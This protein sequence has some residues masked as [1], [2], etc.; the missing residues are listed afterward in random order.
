MITNGLMLGLF[1]E[2][3]LHPGTGAST[4]VVDLPIQRE[5][6]T[7][8]PMIQ[9]SGLKGAMREVAER[10]WDD[11]KNLVNLIFGPPD[12]DH[13]GSIGITDARVLA[14]PVRSLSEVFLW[15]T[16][17][18]II[19]RLKRDINMLGKTD[20]L[21][22][23]S[24]EK[25]KA[26][27][28]SASDLACSFALEEMS[29]DVETSEGT[30]VDKVITVVCGFMPVKES[31]KAVKEKMKKHLVVIHD[32][33]FQY[34]MQNATQVTARNVLNDKKTSEN[35][36]YEESIPPDTLFYTLLLPSVKPMGTHCEIKDAT[37]L[38]EK[39]KMGISGGDYI[40][41]GG[42]ET[43]GMGWCAIKYF[44]G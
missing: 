10:I 14:F 34:L 6:H 33:D 31:H 13:A 17:P 22:D 41:V 2:T 16:C 28:G 39:F 38:I 18:S 7:G 44:G 25:E 12:S 20:D 35:L 24:P 21:P 19:S 23:L 4:G 42:N 11:D 3:S 30:D 15:V 27:V 37:V 8:Y 29:F 26:L 5:K 36:W 9:A 40:Q 43:V 1:A 32:E